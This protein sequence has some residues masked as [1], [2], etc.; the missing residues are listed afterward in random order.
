MWESARPKEFKCT[1]LYVSNAPSTIH[2]G[3]GRIITFYSPPTIKEIISTDIQTTILKLLMVTES[4]S[5]I[6]DGLSIDLIT[7]Q[8]GNRFSMKPSG[9]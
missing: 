7:A 2:S 4:L 5:S 6:V 8:M 3:L 1:L 9:T